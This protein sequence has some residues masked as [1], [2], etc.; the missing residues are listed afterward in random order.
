MR[1]PQ[2]IKE[3]QIDDMHHTIKG[4][5]LIDNIEQMDHLMETLVTMDPLVKTDTC[6]DVDH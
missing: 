4:L 6:Q 5:L 1:F 2:R 3:V